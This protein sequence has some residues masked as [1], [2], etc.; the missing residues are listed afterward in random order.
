MHGGPGIDQAQTHGVADLVGET[1]RLGPRF[2]VDDHAAD[3][4]QTG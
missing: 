4:A 2:A 1:F 3:D